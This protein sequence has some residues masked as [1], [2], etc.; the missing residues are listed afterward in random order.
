MALVLD[1]NGTMTVG[2][3]DITGLATGA[4]PST[5]IGTGAILQVVGTTKTD[6]FS[7]SATATVDIT[8][9]SATITPTSS[10]SKILVLVKLMC[11]NSGA[12]NTSF[13]LQLY[14]NA[15][16]INSGNAAG[17]RPLGFSGSE[18]G[19]S[20]NSYGQYQAYDFS[21]MHLD[22]PGT[23]SAITYKVSVVL[24]QTNTF[25]VNSTAY[26]SDSTAYPRGTSNIILMEVAG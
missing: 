4:L 3:G 9:L 23:T 15:T 13:T 2:N 10:T 20:T 21:S 24:S 14:R 25:Y 5:F 22:S 26:D 7:S 12:Q 18:E 17:S 8:G 1:G 6:V 11:G 16:L 19:I